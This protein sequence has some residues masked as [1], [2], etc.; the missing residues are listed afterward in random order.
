MQERIVRAIEEIKANRALFT[1]DEA[2]IK[3]SVVQRL[4]DILGWD[5]FT[6]MKLFRNT[7]L[8]QGGSTIR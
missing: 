4:L 1:S 2:S 6:L 8:N 5:L 7:R 3:L